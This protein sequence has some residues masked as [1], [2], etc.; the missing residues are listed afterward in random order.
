MA[1]R[2]PMNVL[3]DTCALLALA[4]GEFKANGRAV[5]LGS[6][7]V[8]MFVVGTETDHVAPWRSVYK[9]NLLNEGDITFVLTSGGHNA[10][11]VSEP[12]HPRRHFRIAH[13]AAGAPYLA[14]EAW[15]TA[16]EPRDG[17]WWPLYVDWLSGHSSK[18]ISPP[19]LGTAKFS[20]LCDAPGT[21]VRET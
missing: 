11:I 17:S 19:P 2:S 12:G 1:V 5:D 6:I 8:P 4:R 16:T 14:P 13:R 18:A 20:A 10:G 21:Y 7:R 3:L 15:E 9:I